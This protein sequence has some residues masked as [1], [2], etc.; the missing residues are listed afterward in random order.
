VFVSVGSLVAE[1][2]IT[3]AVGRVA[4]VIGSVFLAFTM[5]GRVA[6]ASV[7]LV[8]L[9]GTAAIARLVVALDI[10]GLFITLEMVG[11]FPPLDTIAFVG[12]VMVVVANI[13]GGTGAGT[14]VGGTELLLT[15]VGATGF[16]ATVVTSGLTESFAIVMKLPTRK[17]VGS[18]KSS[19][20]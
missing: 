17:F 20:R 5:R 7:V 11:R 9:V 10:V 2:V 8:G 15:V 14:T 16:G 18:L 4:A 1:L 13:V 12:A 6:N 19:L 3:G